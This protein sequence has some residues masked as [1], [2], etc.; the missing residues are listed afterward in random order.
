MPVALAGGL[1][2]ELLKGFE[3]PADLG[4][5]DDRP[6]VG[7]RQ[8][9][10]S[11]ASPGGQGDASVV[12]VVADGVVEEVGDQS[13]GELGIAY[14]RRGGDVGV[15]LEPRASGALDYALRQGLAGDFR[16]VEGLLLIEAAFAAGEGEERVDETLLVYTRDEELFADAAEGVEGSAGVGEGDLEQGALH[17]E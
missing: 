10:P 16:E 2:A 15:N 17:G 13:L 3:E 7:D 9:G 4:V 6:G 14:G 8:E 5:G 12:V 1:A 11:G